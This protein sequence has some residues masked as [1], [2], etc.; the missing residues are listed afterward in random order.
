[1]SHVIRRIVYIAIGLLGGLAVWPVMETLLVLQS[2]FSTYL[3]FSLTSGAAFGLVMGAFFGSID[4]MVAGVAR[5]VIGGAFV[6]ALVGAI[7]GAFGF[8]VGQS[9]LVF[10]ASLGNIGI[11]IARS[12]G[13]AILGAA[14]GVGEGVRARSGRRTFVGVTGGA[15]G[16][17]LGG[18]AVEFAPALLPAGY[19]RPVGIVA[20][21]TIVSTAYSI[22]ERGRIFGVLRL[23]NG[24][25]KGTE[26]ILNQR[27]VTIGSRP[28]GDVPLVGYRRVADRHAEIR[29]RGG[30][31]VLVP[32]A[33]DAATIRNDDR[34]GEEDGGF[35]KFGDVIQVGSA[36]M[37]LR[38]LVLLVAVAGALV[39]PRVVAA[40]DATIGQVDTSRLVSRQEIDLYV[41]LVDS[42]GQAIGG[43]TSEQVRVAETDALGAFQPVEVLAVEERAAETD[44]V[45]FFL[46]VDNSGSMYDTIDGVPTEDPARTR[47]A[48]VQTAIRRFLDQ[49]DN[50]RDRFA[51][52]VFNTH[53]RL[54]TEP[55][56]SVRTVDLLL[57]EIERPQ[58][59]E[60]YTE[61]FRA[62]GLAAEELSEIEG[63]RVIV[64]LS[65][66]EDYPFSVHSGRPHPEYGE[67]L[68]TIE[69]SMSAV[70][71]AG[72][73]AYAIGFAGDG[74][75][76][77]EEIVD[78]AGGIVFRADDAR[79]LESVY[80]S[81]RDRILAEYRITY[82]ASITPEE[83][84]TVR[85]S[86]E[87][88]AGPISERR[89]CFAGTIF[90]L[91]RDDFGPILLMP[92]LG[93]LLATA[94]LSLLRSRSR[95]STASIELLNRSGVATSVLDLSAEKTV[96]G[97]ATDADVTIA[98]SPDM[99]DHHATIVRDEKRGT[100]TLM[101]TQ[102]VTVNNK[103]Y[104]KRRLRAGD[105]IELPG[106]TIV[107]DDPED[108]GE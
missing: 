18:L 90:G 4:G 55:T 69:D 97:A 47:M 94:L 68:A 100:F 36:K 79:E 102:A 73:G 107:F 43:I 76:L 45:T 106:A 99:Q 103:R 60:A 13:W 44:G 48:A 28:G 65:D 52:A 84:R 95:R 77:V 32:L 42:G 39:S 64:I 38:P 15:I 56:D 62:V 41:S 57:D 91:P 10:F 86:V 7:G 85:V 17:F 25:R 66:G 21:G 53:Y 30:H 58:P 104:T 12:L 24:P 81:I 93:A 51:L 63:R 80:A 20:Y 87:S 6:G 3:L 98:G 23:L 8:F 71:R 33:T 16:G 74:E 67:Q 19:A 96:I 35:L 14:V 72:A 2:R 88:P 31:L 40:Q 22:V 54:L 89:R 34:V 27:R 101:S 37:L 61:L 83:Y 108:D 1:M 9:A 11:A 26:F 46:L 82:R 105:V 75:P 5:R 50:P 78:S 59:D 70:E 92:F 29:D 49:I